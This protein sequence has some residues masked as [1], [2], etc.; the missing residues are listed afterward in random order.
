MLEMLLNAAS[1]S[2]TTMPTSALRMILRSR[3]AAA[4]P[5]VSGMLP[6]AEAPLDEET[7]AWAAAGAAAVAAGRAAAA[8][9]AGAAFAARAAVAAG[10]G[11][12]S[13][14]DVFA[15]REPLVLQAAA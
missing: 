5:E 10:A 15:D 8:L 14:V 7:G 3:S 6:P 9:A 4:P 12:F 11:A 2:F 1:T 13:E